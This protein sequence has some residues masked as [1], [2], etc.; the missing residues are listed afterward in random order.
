MDHIKVPSN[1]AHPHPKVAFLVHEYQGG[2]FQGY[3]ERCGIPSRGYHETFWNDVPSESAAPVLQSWLFFGLLEE[4]LEDKVRIED[5]TYEEN[6][7]KYLTTRRLPGRIEK[8][9]QAVSTTDPDIKLARYKILREC[10]D[11]AQQT[12]LKVPESR[13]SLYFLHQISFLNC[14]INFHVTIASSSSLL[15]CSRA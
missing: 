3:P 1:P 14:G 11:I 10:Q 12:L 2:P 9:V 13:Q 8:W 5:F 7:E 4:V 6:G 15:K